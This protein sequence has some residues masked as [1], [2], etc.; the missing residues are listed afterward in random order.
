MW[1]TVIHKIKLYTFFGPMYFRDL[2]GLNLHLT[3]RIFS[4]DRH[5]VLISVT[6]KNCFQPLRSHLYF[7]NAE[8]RP[9]ARQ[10][11]KFSIK[12]FFM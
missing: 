4:L 7:D 5:F 9:D 10:K 8:E 3:G 12:D 6:S 2:L 11:M 1:V